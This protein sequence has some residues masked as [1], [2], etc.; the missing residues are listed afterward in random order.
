M[1]RARKCFV[2][3]RIA[4]QHSYGVAVIAFYR[5]DRSEYI[6]PHNTVMLILLCL[7]DIALPSSSTLRPLCMILGVTD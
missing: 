7:S 2:I 6:T 3:R 1:K 5:D 4:R